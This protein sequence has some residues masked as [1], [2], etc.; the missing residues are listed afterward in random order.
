MKTDLF[1]WGVFYDAK[2]IPRNLPVEISPGDSWEEPDRNPAPKAE[3]PMEWT[4]PS[5]GWVKLNTTAISRGG[6]AGIGGS[7]HG[8]L[9]KWIFG[10]VLNLGQDSCTQLRA[11]LWALL[12]GLKLVS[13]RGYKK[14]QVETDSQQALDCLKTNPD[15]S[16]PNADFIG[17][18]RK[19]LVGNWQVS[20]SLV[21]RERNRPAILVVNDFES[22][23]MGVLTLID[24][25]PPDLAGSTEDSQ[26]G[27]DS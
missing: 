4:P 15:E 26:V 25:P 23:H 20:Q 21:T 19:L 3:R 10:Y 27:Q 9:G 7:V 22:H 13:E 16:D 17:A 18:C 14:V 24:S 6:V 2:N 12:Y 1:L 11:D 5:T 8:P